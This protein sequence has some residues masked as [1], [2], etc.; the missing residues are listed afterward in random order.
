MINIQKI[1]KAFILLFVIGS[2]LS[3]NDDDNVEAFDV[4]GDVFTTTRMINGE[5]QYAL[6]YYAYGNQPMSAAK[7]TTPDSDE[8]SLEAANSLENTW[9]KDAELDDFSTDL[10]F[11]GIYLFDVLHQDVPHEANDILEFYEL[12]FTLIVSLDMID[13][14]LT[15]EW[16]TNDDAEA[17]MIRLINDDGEAIFGSALLSPNATELPVAV[18]NASGTWAAGYPNVGDNYDLELH[19]FTFD[20]DAG[21][22]D[23]SYHIQEITITEEEVTWE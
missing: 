8:F 6:S 21:E 12:P 22:L 4:I 17:Y 10:P 23:F 20:A 15:V 18:G 2:M 7:V 3:C 19:A 9:S 11:E 14:V 16:E 1:T 5:A 13:Q